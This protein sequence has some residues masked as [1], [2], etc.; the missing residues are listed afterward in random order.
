MV[1]NIEV[2]I[3]LIIKNGMK[4][5]KLMIKVVCNLLVINVGIKIISGVFF[6]EFNLL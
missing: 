3:K 1:I 6:G 4:N 5:I 2:I